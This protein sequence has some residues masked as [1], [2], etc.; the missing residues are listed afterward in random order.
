MH[1]HHR[2]AV[3]TRIPRRTQ[4][5]H[6]YLHL[7]PCSPKRRAC[8]W[9]P[10]S[11]HSFPNECNTDNR[12]RYRAAF[13]QQVELVLAGPKMAAHSLGMLYVSHPLQQLPDHPLIRTHPQHQ[14]YSSENSHLE[15]SSHGSISLLCRSFCRVYHSPD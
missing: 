7:W 13:S 4:F 12:S 11:H 9:D 6:Q 2:S 3:L 8:I 5:H 1:L 10:L 15:T 14:R